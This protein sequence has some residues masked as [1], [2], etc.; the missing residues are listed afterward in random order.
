MAQ[1][2]KSRYEKQGY[3]MKDKLTRHERRGLLIA[4]AFLFV[5][6]QSDAGAPV[7]LV[8]LGLAVCVA[9]AGLTYW[10]W[11]RAKVDRRRR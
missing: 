10:D 1:Q 4:L 7:A 3:S 6:G 5:G 11:R 8:A 9:L 2:A